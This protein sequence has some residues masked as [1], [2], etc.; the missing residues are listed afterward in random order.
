MQKTR[1]EQNT[2]QTA[3]KPRPGASSRAAAQ[4]ARIRP[5]T[6]RDRHRLHHGGR[7]RRWRRESQ[8]RA[9]ARGNPSLFAPSKPTNFVAKLAVH[10]ER[11]TVDPRP[12]GD[13]AYPLV[14]ALSA[15][16][17]CTL[18]FCF[19]GRSDGGWPLCCATFW[20][21][22]CGRLAA[23]WHVW[24]PADVGPGDAGVFV[25]RPSLYAVWLIIR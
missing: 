8:R 21:V 18:L 6:R 7:G 3:K 13:D 2:T 10:G 1:R 5:T 14:S 25:C 9:H 17:Q 22:A 23:R 11:R 24:A 12:P 19:A 16:W 15:G 4:H 20:P